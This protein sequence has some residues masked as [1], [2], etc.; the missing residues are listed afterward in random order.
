MEDFKPK[1]KKIK[2]NLKPQALQFYL[3]KSLFRLPKD[4][5]MKNNYLTITKP[6]ERTAVLSYERWVQMAQHFISAVV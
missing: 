2:R 3:I 4:N 5:I 6:T 1:D